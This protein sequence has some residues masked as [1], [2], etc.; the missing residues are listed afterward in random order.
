M[1]LLFENW[2]RY[3][4][5][6]DLA[7]TVPRKGK[8][9]KTAETEPMP[10]EKLLPAFFEVLLEDPETFNL[11][12]EETKDK[13]F[14]EINQRPYFEDFIKDMKEEIGSLLAGFSNLPV[15]KDYL[16]DGYD[17]KN[18]LKFAAELPDDKRKAVLKSIGVMSD[19]FSDAA[20]AVGLMVTAPNEIKLY[21]CLYQSGADPANISSEEFIKCREEADVRIEEDL[22]KS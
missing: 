2:R 21:S 16:K 19:K 11:V 20:D 1:K 12:P 9:I 15:V 6:E 14:E 8:R 22:Q 5:E 4:K 7:D 10:V 17:R 3:L 18:F 13:S